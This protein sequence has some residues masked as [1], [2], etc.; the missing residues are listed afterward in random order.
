LLAI[1]VCY[2]AVPAGAPRLRTCMSAIHE[3]SDLD[4]ALDVLERAGRETGLIE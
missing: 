4:F 2:P 1:P 3:R